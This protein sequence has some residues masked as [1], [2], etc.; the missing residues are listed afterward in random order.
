MAIFRRKRSE[1]ALRSSCS[2]R[3]KSCSA[4]SIIG[5]RTTSRSSEPPQPPG[6]PPQGRRGHD[7][8]QTERAPHPLD[9]P[10][11]REAVPIQGPG[12]DRHGRLHRQP[13]QHLFQSFRIDPGLV[14]FRT[15]IRD[16]ALDINTAMP[17]G[18]LISELVRRALKH[19]FPGSGG[20][21]SRSSSA[22][23]T[24]DSTPWS[25]GTTGRASRP[26]SI[27]GG[28][29]RS[30]CRAVLLVEQLDGAIELPR[31]PG[32]AGR[33]SR[34][35][36]GRRRRWTGPC[37][38]PGSLSSKTRAWSP[39]TSRSSTRSRNSPWPGSRPRPQQALKKV[40]DSPP[41]LVLMDIVLKG[42]LDGIAT[43]AAIRSRRDI[44][45]HLPDGRR[46]TSDASAWP[47]SPTPSA[48]FSSPSRSGSS[49]I[50]EMALHKHAA[51]KPGSWSG[52]AG[53]CRSSTASRMRSSPPMSRDGS[54]S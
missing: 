47:T 21:R 50:I 6:P 32:R 16:V 10:R 9:G 46:L 39:A 3:R 43:A 44:P 52:S 19:A 51:G 37:P 28:R 31:P 11:P 18:L 12:P 54:C 13:A 42:Q 35:V 17:C 33:S 24:R 49:M 53:R 20:G 36:P 27:S 30:G 48:I 5:S 2:A 45:D 7:F 4:R 25:S 38:R 40:E 15:D 29:H 41:D 34:P 1:E 23:P 22:P 26:G 14:R 8:S